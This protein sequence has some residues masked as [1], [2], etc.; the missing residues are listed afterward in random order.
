M[1]R[2]KL[3]QRHRKFLGQRNRPNYPAQSRALKTFFARPFLFAVPRKHRTT[4]P[5]FASFPAGRR[6]WFRP[7]PILYSHHAHSPSQRVWDRRGH[8]L[9]VRSPGILPAVPLPF[10]RHSGG[11]QARYPW[12]YEGVLVDWL[13]C[14]ERASASV[15]LQDEGDSIDGMGGRRR[16]LALNGGPSDQTR[17]NILSESHNT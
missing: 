1:N 17:G 15:I 4:L 12:R 13:W 3:L 9:R 14:G 11:R 10:R 5:S 7:S 2:S 16:N 6:M 8:S